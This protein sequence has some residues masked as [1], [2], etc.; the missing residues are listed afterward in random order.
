MVKNTM[1]TKELRL[2]GEGISRGIAIGDAFFFSYDDIA[3]PD[4]EVETHS[5]K[6]ELA[7]FIEAF[8][9]S[10]E[11]I[12]QIRERLVAEDAVEAVSVLEAQLAF[13]ADPT[14]L[15][16]MTSAIQEQYRNAEAVFHSVWYRYQLQFEAMEDPFFRE[17]FAD[18]EDLYR[19]VL[20]HLLG[21]SGIGLSAV[22]NGSVVFAVDLAPSDTAS[23]Q[24]RTIAAFVTQKGGATSHAAI[25]AR[26][27][28]IPYVGNLDLSNIPRN[29]SGPV[30]VD[31]RTGA[32][33]LNPTPATLLEYQSIRGE[34]HEFLHGFQGQAFH[35]TET[36]DGHSLRISANLESGEELAALKEYGGEGIGLFRSEYLYL[37]R[38]RFPTEEEQFQA[39]RDILVSMQGLPVVI[40]AFD[41][42]GDKHSIEQQTCKELNPFLGCRAIRFLLRKPEIFR[43]QLRAVLRASAFGEVS[44]LFPLVSSL[45]ELREVKSIVDEVRIKLL[46][47]GHEIASNLRIGSMVEVPSAALIADLLAGECDFLSIGT[48]DLVQYALAVDRGNDAMSGLYSPTHPGVLRLLKFVITQAQRKGIP[49]SLCGEMAADPRL[50]PLLIGLGLHELSVATRHI[51]LIKNIIRRTSIVDARRIA[52]QVLTMSEPNEILNFLSAEYQYAVPED[53]LFN[54][55]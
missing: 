10:R 43:T 1:H 29:L 49:V 12:H 39:Y 53:S 40:R 7:R 55:M 22:P 21:T 48:N 25:V 20:K 24:E 6:N 16:D 47:Q 38:N 42:G 9:R 44:L 4:Y 2:L 31:G 17:R 37:S 19:R 45:Q 15:A 52:E 54:I 28:G 5:V 3:I 33:I 26:A 36:Y 11:E 34:L 32:V 41:V 13:V 8:D 50:T 18:L 14:I 35:Q 46:D 23:V 27:K 51:P 30:I